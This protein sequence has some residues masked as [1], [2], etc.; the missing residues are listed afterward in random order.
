M[1][2]DAVS[3][4]AA[5]EHR[6]SPAAP[7]R[8]HWVLFLLFLMMTVNYADRGVLN[9]LVQP[10]KQ[11]LKLSDFQVGALGG[12]SFAILHM[13]VAIPIAWAAER[14]SRIR[15][16]ALALILWSGLTALCGG[17]QNFVQLALLR[18]GIGLGEAGAS[19]PGQSLVGD[20]F[21]ANKRA[22]ALSV[23]NLGIPL[24]GMLGALIG[25]AVADYYGWRAAFVVLGLPGIFLALLFLL[26]LKEPERGYHD[27]HV[28]GADRVEGLLASCLTIFRS[29][30]FVLFAVASSLANL[31]N[32]GVN[33]FNAAFYVRKFGL[34]LLEVGAILGISAAASTAV[35]ILF[36]GMLADAAARR[37]IRWYAWIS[38]LGMFIAGPLTA[39]AFSQAAWQ[40]TLSLQIVTGIC[41]ML[42]VGP[43]LGTNQNLAPVR[44]RATSVAMFNL[45]NVGIGYGLGPITVGYFGDH[46]ARRAF[47]T[48]GL[49][50]FRVICPGG[51]AP[52]HATAAV[53]DACIA[54][55]ASGLQ[56]ALVGTAFVYILGGILFLAAMFTI[57]RDLARARPT[58]TAGR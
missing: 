56:E 26:T 22:T 39:L 19:P 14:F 33:Q 7:R 37:D 21:P 25:G 44:M 36:G 52:A 3:H 32:Q 31:A 53:H 12:L 15:I 20:Y 11:E 42:Y 9:I 34:H 30:T 28:V 57:R 48:A 29:P 43:I 23:M 54:A 10:I 51:V 1:R 35:G 49:G 6:A 55:S 27:R 8:R 4:P 46:A 50:D 17:A 41:S 47:A 5:E 16:I 18:V 13:S 40:A 38:A 2:L 58:E 24:G 45:V